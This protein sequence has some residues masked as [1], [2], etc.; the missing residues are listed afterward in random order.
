M[1]A[2]AQT[3][4]TVL[5]IVTQLIR[6]VCGLALFVVLIWGIVTLFSSVSHGLMMIGMAV[7]AGWLLNI[8][9][10]LLMLAAVTLLARES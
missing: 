10:A 9:S 5:M 1:S 6:F 8:L 2:F 4:G 3:C 7:L